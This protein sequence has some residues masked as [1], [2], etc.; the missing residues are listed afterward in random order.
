MRSILRP[1]SLV[2]LVLLVATSPAAAQRRV[3]LG[4]DAGAVFGLGHTSSVS[5]TLPGSRFRAGFFRPGSRISVEP[6]LG[7]G[8]HK[9]EGVTGVFTYDLELGTLFH[10]RPIAV[11]NEGT[12]GE[13]ARVIPPYI[14]PFVGVTGFS[15]GGSDSEFSAGVGL[16]AKVPWRRDLALRFEANVGYGFDNKATRIG[17]LAGLSYFPR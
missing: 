1:A 3:E 2:V 11:E 5:I 6:S 10:F 9:V 8:Y 15:G 12:G 16:G 4:I 13:V 14:R 17:A 7:L